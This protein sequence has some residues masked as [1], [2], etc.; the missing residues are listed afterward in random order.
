MNRT[1]F[2]EPI[3]RAIGA[4]IAP[5]CRAWPCLHSCAPVGAINCLHAR[6]RATKRS[7]RLDSTRADPF[8]AGE[9]LLRNERRSSALF[10]TL[11]RSSPPSAAHLAEWCC[12]TRAAPAPPGGRGRTRE[13]EN[14]RAK[15]ATPTER[16]RQNNPFQVP[17][18]RT[19]KPK[20]N[21]GALSRTELGRADR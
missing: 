6:V 12:A 19:G 20:R 14:R 8:V 2:A 15:L 3:R 21:G 4:S 17:L 9:H 7:A 11:R 10:G 1:S 18:A 16:L 13:H 5:V